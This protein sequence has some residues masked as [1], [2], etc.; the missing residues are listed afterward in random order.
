MIFV[1]LI[2]R[3]GQIAVR[4]RQIT[5]VKIRDAVS[6]GLTTFLGI[7]YF[8]KDFFVCFVSL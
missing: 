2:S 3:W 4:F 7:E 8:L 5:N 6:L 1:F